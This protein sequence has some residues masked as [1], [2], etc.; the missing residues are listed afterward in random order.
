MCLYPYPSRGLRARARVAVCLLATLLG[1]QGLQAQLE[2]VGYDP[3]RH[4]RFYV[5]PDRDF[6]AEDLDLTGVG[7][8][9]GS[10][11]RW[12]TLLTPT[13]FVSADHF[14]PA[15]GTTL[16]FYHSNDPDGPF[17]ERT[18]IGFQRIFVDDQ[19]SDV[20]LG[21]LD[22][23]VSDAIATYPIASFPSASAYQGAQVYVVGRSDTDSNQFTNMRV[24]RGVIQGFL[25]IPIVN[26]AGILTNFTDT[27][28]YNQTNAQNLLG[29]DAALL[30]LFDSGGPSF[31]VIDGQLA[32]VGVHSAV[33]VNLRLSFDTGLFLYLDEILAATANAV[34]TLEHK[35]VQSATITVQPNGNRVI[36]WPNT[37]TDIFGVFRSNDPFA[38]N[39]V[40]T[41]ISGDIE[42]GEGGTLSFEDTSPVL[43][44]QFYRVRADA[45]GSTLF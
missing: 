15:V 20:Y 9:N 33:N 41:Q 28:T 6:L 11:G 43:D 31:V 42:Y 16:R 3:A 40:W 45:F 4:D 13:T 19:T 23:P 39:P 2:I 38:E 24:G 22:S 36:S 8:I 29:G 25:S 7:R 10:A 37:S 21:Q 44:Q 12:G 26:G 30:V 17:E 5:G 34:S 27:Y 35:T 1:I 32:I 14:A 18:V